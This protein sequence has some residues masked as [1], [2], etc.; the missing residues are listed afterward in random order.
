MGAW[1]RPHALDPAA[2]VAG[3][4]ALLGVLTAMSAATFTAGLKYAGIVLGTVLSSTAPLF[5]L[6]IGFLAF[7]ERVTWRAIM[8]AALAVAGI[9]VL[10]F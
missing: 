7:G 10:N 2:G 8:G 4:V 9:A 5:A 3:R 1:H 6:P